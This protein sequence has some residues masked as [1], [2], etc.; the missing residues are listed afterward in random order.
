[1]KLTNA[2][3][4]LSKLKRD[5]EDKVVQ[6]FLFLASI[7]TIYDRKSASSNAT[8]AAVSGKAIGVSYNLAV[9]T[10]TPCC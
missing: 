6:S 2:S 5:W 1:M 8:N 10:V 3:M 9:L 4:T 7:A